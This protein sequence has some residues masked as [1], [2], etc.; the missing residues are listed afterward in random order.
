[1]STFGAIYIAN[2]PA[3]GKDVYKIGVTERSV[4]ERMAELTASTSNLGRYE[5][6]GYV[7]V[8][9]MQEA[10]LRCHN[11][12]SYCRVQD[13]REFFEE[14]LETIVRIVRECCQPFEIKDYLPVT[15]AEEPPNV[16]EIV[17]RTLEKGTEE[18]R[19]VDEYHA[20]VSESIREQVRQ[21]LPLLA[22]LKENL[23]SE[24]LKALIYDPQ[25][26]F[27][28]Q[29]NRNRLTQIKLVDVMF[30]GRLVKTP[31]KIR[32]YKCGVG[33][34]EFLQLSRTVQVAQER[35][36]ESL[37][38]LGSCLFDDDGR[39]LQISG[40]IK[41]IWANPKDKN[42]GDF[43]YGHVFEIKVSMFSCEGNSYSEEATYKT[44]DT[45]AGLASV[46]DFVR[47]LAT[48]CADNAKLCPA[49]DRYFSSREGRGSRYANLNGSH[50]SQQ[51]LVQA[52]NPY[53]V[54]REKTKRK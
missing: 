47:I 36:Y 20:I 9:D 39:W 19:A 40:S 7:V 16:R 13:N 52:L 31:I 49:I 1:M 24:N 12:L 5:A 21:V 50:V 35:Q 17:S 30:F 41:C 14:A 51:A 27:A 42:E 4:P 29:P 23:P 37:P 10:E 2:N 45:S 11:K 18:K 54:T 6:I 28:R 44:H 15:K 34:S 53:L 38:Q 46:K 25:F 32:V 48:V 26:D 8:N 3:D 33:S 43:L 22:D